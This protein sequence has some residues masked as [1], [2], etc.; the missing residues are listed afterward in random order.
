MG[1]LFGDYL[2]D[3]TE[4]NVYLKH[5]GKIV[6]I[7]ASA[8]FHRYGR[9]RRILF[10]IVIKEDYTPLF[11][12]LTKYVTDMCLYQGVYP[13]WVFDG[14]RQPA[15][16]NTMARRRMGIA[17]ARQEA[18]AW[19]EKNPGSLDLP[20]C[21]NN[22][23]T[24]KWEHVISFIDEL[25]N[26][27]LSYIRS[28]GEADGQL[29]ALLN[30]R[31][32][33]AVLSRDTDLLAIG[34][35][36]GPHQLIYNQISWNSGIGNIRIFRKKNSDL[37]K[38]LT[39]FLSPVNAKLFMTGKELD[40][41]S[42]R[43]VSFVIILIAAVT[44][45][46]CS[47]PR[48]GYLTAILHLRDHATDPCK[49][50]LKQLALR[51]HFFLSMTEARKALEIVTG[52]QCDEETVKMYRVALVSLKE[53]IV[54]DASA[55]TPGFV[56]LTSRKSVFDLTDEWL[57][58]MGIQKYA[59][60]ESRESAMR[61]IQGEENCDGSTSDLVPVR[62]VVYPGYRRAQPLHAEL[63]PSGRFPDGT[64]I[65]ALGKN[66]PESLRNFLRC[67]EGF[68][69]PER[70][71]DLIALVKDCITQEK[72]NG[73]YPNFRDPCGRS[74]YNILFT[75][76]YVVENRGTAPLPCDQS[77]CR[78]S[79]YLTPRR[80]VATDFPAERVNE[81]D[82]LDLDK[83]GQEFVVALNSLAPDGIA[84]RFGLESIT[85]FAFGCEYKDQ[86]E[87]RLIRIGRERIDTL[88]FFPWLAITRVPKD[89]RAK[90]ISG[91]FFEGKIPR[92]FTNEYYT[93]CLKLTGTRQGHDI[94]LEVID[95]ACECRAK[96]AKSCSHRT[97]L[98]FVL[99]TLVGDETVCTSKARKWKLPSK[100]PVDTT[101]VCATIQELHE[102]YVSKKKKRKPKETKK[103][104]K[105]TRAD[106]LIYNK[107]LRTLN[108][109]QIEN[110]MH[111]VEA[112][113]IFVPEAEN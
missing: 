74:L 12:F 1:L 65:D 71:A 30:D 45:D 43:L 75:R 111:P 55:P 88:A 14:E 106:I 48:V 15:K 87:R 113:P 102:A 92:S 39:S 95:S 64:D 83:T 99:A 40:D 96:N 47:V 21:F 52:R 20:S 58:A 90:D 93:P 59:N 72:K 4:K 84:I 98:C 94:E 8:L 56:T 25:R 78:P 80:V 97:A 33:D 105:Q 104:F 50:F 89:P 46:Y 54:Y 62:R 36:T 63:L 35:V 11:Q 16:A 7:D 100:E 112:S 91:F 38:C 66:D 6:G 5:R 3:M 76:A 82:H 23:F 37:M 22:A 103:P 79:I 73:V 68:P 61:Y 53:Q 32:I 2:R 17:D 110:D 85:N 9:V 51:G 108:A 26:N 49:N 101:M 109:F 13:L 42:S 67:R 81:L 107:G 86:T 41:T 34:K 69:V 70:R 18:L 77:T 24:I 27:G 28:P 19:A 60:I 57:D 31:V 29:I 10:D 44:C